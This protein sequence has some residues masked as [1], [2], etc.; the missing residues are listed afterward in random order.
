VI[1]TAVGALAGAALGGHDGA[2]VGAGVGLITGAAAGGG[3]SAVATRD[4]QRHYDITYQ[5]CMY[6]M[7]NQLPGYYR[8]PTAPPQAARPAYYPPSPSVPA[9]AASAPPPGIPPP[10]P[11]TPPPPPP[12]A[13]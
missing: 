4:M 12:G 8:Q 7:G 11:G 2:A 3:E 1:A 10:P 5:Q 9:P 6:S 13:R